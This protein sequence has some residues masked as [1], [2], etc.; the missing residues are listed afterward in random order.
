VIIVVMGCSF[1]QTRYHWQHRWV[2]LGG[3]L[4]L[5]VLAVPLLRY[6]LAHPDALVQQLTT[7][8]PY[9]AQNIPFFDKLGHYFSN[10]ASGLSPLYWFIPNQH[11]L[12][13]H[14]MKGYGHLFLLT[15]PFFIAGLVIVLTRLRSSAHRAILFAMLASPAG[16]CGIELP[17]AGLR[18]R[19]CDLDGAGLDL[20]LVA[21][22]RGKWLLERGDWINKWIPFEV[23][24]IVLGAV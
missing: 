11:D 8:A 19:R 16:G 24:S 10:Y 13:R 3:F 23:L 7:R 14:L 22:S 20:V 2:A 9:W 15:F 17:S 1:F 6:S 5:A 21:G 12:P 18:H 4:L